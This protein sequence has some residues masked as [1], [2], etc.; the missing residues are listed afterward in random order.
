VA[1]VEREMTVTVWYLGSGEKSRIGK[2]DERW[3]ALSAESRR[4]AE[5]GLGP[6][7]AAMDEIGW[8]RKHVLLSPMEQR[9]YSLLDNLQCE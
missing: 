2:H 5:A 7:L 1:N 6:L 9:S 8:Q 3:Q 4:R